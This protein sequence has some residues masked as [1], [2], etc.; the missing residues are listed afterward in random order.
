MKYMGSKRAMLSNGLGEMLRAEA[1]NYSRVVDLFG[2]AS[3]VSWFA[4]QELKKPVLTVDLQ[5]YSAVMARAVLSRTKPI[6]AEE[7]WDKWGKVITKKM[8]SRPGWKYAK[9][10]DSKLPNA[11]T[12]SKQAREL[13]ASVQARDA[14]IWSSYGGY[15]FSPTQA[16]AFDAML[17]CL[18]DREP[19][20]SVY[21][22]A[23]IIV[24]SKCAASPG[25]T[26]QPFRPTSTA[27]PF[28]RE[29]WQRDPIDYF[30]RALLDICPRHALVRGHAK[31]ADAVEE[32]RKLRSTDFVFVDPPYS[33]VH[34]SRFY[35][36]LETIAR[37]G[38][39]PVSGDGRYPPFEERPQSSFSN[40]SESGAALALLLERLA[41][42]G[43]TVLF[44]FPASRCSNG[45]SGKNIEM[46]AGKR[47]VIEKKYVTS[48][49]ST[50]GGNNAHRKA[51]A[52]RK[53]L[54]LLMRP[55]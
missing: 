4:A 16:L 10:L 18:P 14:V 51:R 50:L 17:H 5:T 22:A 23:I 33:G 27:G 3:A 26:A 49:F 31:I 6:D 29:A 32:A 36:V 47:F 13:C 9:T 42:A 19:L 25:H 30:R 53:E 44:T 48:K 38:C 54:M 15:Y 35:H 37:G 2:G 7:M 39:G 46:E 55:Q 43:C 41:D 52:R 12:W 40:K 34:Y 8:R 11:H 24:A 21:L 45:L 1:V 20:R 28:L